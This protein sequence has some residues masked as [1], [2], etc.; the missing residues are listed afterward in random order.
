MIDVN[1]YSLKGVGCWIFVFF[2][3]FDDVIY[4]LGKFVCGVERF[5]MVGFCLVSNKCFCNLKSKLF[6]FIIL[7]YFC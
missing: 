5:K 1:L 7:Y 4:D 6:F 2:M 3:G